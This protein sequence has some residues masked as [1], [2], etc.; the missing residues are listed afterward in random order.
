MNTKRLAPIALVACLAGCATY[1]GPQGQFDPED[2]GEANRMTY[3]A[4]VVDPDPEYAEPMEGSAEHAADAIEAYRE[5][6]VE[7]PEQVKS[8]QTQ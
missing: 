8:T 3:A 5:G 2:F 4:M 7:E 1:G 6:S